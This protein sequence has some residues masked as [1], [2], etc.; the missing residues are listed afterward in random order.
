MIRRVWIA[1]VLLLVLFEGLRPVAAGLVVS[2]ADTT[3]QAGA[4]GAVDVHLSSSGTDLL[5]SF[6]VEFQIT[7]VGATSTTLQFAPTGNQPDPTASG[8]YVFSGDSAGFVPAVDPLGTTVPYDTFVGSDFTA[9]FADIAVGTSPVL[10]ARLQI[11]DLLPI[12]G[13]APGDHFQIALAPG[14]GD[15][16]GL[17]SGTSNTGFLDAAFDPIEFT[18]HAGTITV[19][20][21]SSAPEPSSVTML[22]LSLICVALCRRLRWRRLNANNP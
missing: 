6:E 17:L 18:S 2:I 12:G 19:G 10:L 13:V 16:S 5:Q 11:A 4:S 20:P 9:S 7:P 22:A 21:A 15:S 8:N 1:G 3:V 14:S